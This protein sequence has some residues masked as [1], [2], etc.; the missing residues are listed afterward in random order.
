MK[1][2][3]HHIIRTQIFGKFS[4]IISSLSY[5]N[6]LSGTQ[7]SSLLLSLSSGGPNPSHLD[8]ITE[9]VS[10]Q[11][12]SLL[13]HTTAI[14]HK[15]RSHTSQRPGAVG[16]STAT[17]TCQRHKHKPYKHSHL[18]C[19]QHYSQRLAGLLVGQHLVGTVFT[20]PFSRNSDGYRLS[21]HALPGFT[22]NVSVA[23]LPSLE[24]VALPR[25]ART[26]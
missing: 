8:D 25:I 18:H 13:H 26:H 16:T 3:E 20:P 24:I 15:C 12:R 21:C 1:Y 11:P 22:L 5:L 14:L 23:S 9:E 4:F 7:S 19:H 2:P 17:C 6:H 10:A